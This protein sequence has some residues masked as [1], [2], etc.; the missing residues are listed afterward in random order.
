[1]QLSITTRIQLIDEVQILT[2]TMSLFLS[3][4]ITT[5]TAIITTTREYIKN[6]TVTEVTT[7]MP[8]FSYTP[9]ETTKVPSVTSTTMVPTELTTATMVP[10]ITSTTMAPTETTRAPS[11][12]TTTM[13]P[14][15]TTMAPTETTQPRSVTTQPPTVPPST[16]PY[17][18]KQLVTSLAG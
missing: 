12:T 9:T 5:L 6:F 3:A 11:G 2:F 8:T 10:S 4:E 13:A 15:S 18:G 16:T 14:T 17:Q 1:M 7:E